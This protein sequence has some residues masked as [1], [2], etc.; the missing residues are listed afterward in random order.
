[1]RGS[2][3]VAQVTK[4]IT[5][6]RLNWCGHVKRSDEGQVLSRM[7]DVPVPGKRWRGRPKTRWKDSCKRDMESMAL[8]EVS[9]KWKNYIRAIPANQ[10]DGKSLRRRRRVMIYLLQLCVYICQYAIDDLSPQIQKFTLFAKC[11]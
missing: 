5:E 2:E 1:M 4:K 10:D 9:T 11:T 6:K 8:K 3:K 7:L